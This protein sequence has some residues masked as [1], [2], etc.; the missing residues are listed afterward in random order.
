[1]EDCSTDERLQEEML[2]RQ[3]WTDEYIE[4]SESLMKQ[5]SVSAGRRS[6]SRIDLGVSRFKSTRVDLAIASL[7]ESIL[8]T[9]T[10]GFVD[11]S[12]FCFKST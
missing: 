4:H 11:L 1:M 10:T 12:R 2:C 5:D 7:V 9:S 8:L 3:Q 6:S